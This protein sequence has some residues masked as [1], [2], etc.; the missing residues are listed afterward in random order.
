MKFSCLPYNGEPCIAQL[1]IVHE[2]DHIKI[3]CFVRNEYFQ[4]TPEER[5]RQAF[6]WFLLHGSIHS[7]KW[8]K[9]IAVN[10]EQADI[11]ITLSINSSIK[12]FNI[13]VPLLLIETKRDNYPFIENPNAEEQLR[14]YLLRRNCKDGILFNGGSLFYVQC[15]HSLKTQSNELHDLSELDTL[16]ET[17]LRGSQVQLFR[18]E[19]LFKE[20]QRGNYLA[21]K[22]LAVCYGRRHT[23]K[24]EYEKEGKL[25]RERG[26]LFSEKNDALLYKVR[27][28]ATKR[29]QQLVKKDFRELVS[30]IEGAW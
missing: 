19:Q 16:L 11:D 14:K 5:V 24:I 21:F 8:C 12:G 22:E 10:V 7:E 28:V 20:A 30:I 9:Q 27:G 18:N 23:F 13:K 29:K 6:L 15:D 26:F 3:K 1:E 4:L 2:D 25:Y 17:L